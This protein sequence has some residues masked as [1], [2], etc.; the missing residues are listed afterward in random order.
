MGHPQTPLAAAA[1]WAEKMPDRTYLVQPIAGD[2]VVEYSWA[3][4]MDQARRMATWLKGQ[5][6]PE[7]SQI[8]IV[9]KNCAHWVIADLAIWAA[10]HV[11]VP[12]FATLSADGAQ[13]I[14]EHS[15][16]KLLFVGK[17][18]VWD[19]MKAGFPAD[20]PKVGLPLAPPDES[21]QRWDD[22]VRANEPLATL[23]ERTPDSVATIIYTSGSTGTPKGVMTSFRSLAETG[24]GIA[25][26]L[27][28]VPE[29]RGLSY[30]P[31]AHSFERWI[32]ETVSLMAAYQLYFA[33]SADTFVQDLRRARP[34]IFISVPRLWLK[35]QLGVFKKM[36]PKKLARLLKIPILGGIVRK[37]ILRGLGLDSVRF[38]G[39]GSAPIPAE[40]I[41]WYR[42]LGLELLEGYGMTENGSYS[43]VS[44]PGRVR[45]GYVGE[46]LPGVEHK[47]GE[48]D[49]V[50]VKGPGTM[51]G[52]FKA[53][54]LTA[55]V[56]EPD[57]WL[58]TGDQ[59]LIDEQNRLKITG[60]VKEL[61]KTSKGKYVSPSTIENALLTS[62]RLELACVSGGGFPQ[63]FALVV[64]SEETRK[65]L[66]NGGDRAAVEAELKAHLDAV[67]ALLPAY[68]HLQFAVV[69][70]EPWSTENGF[71]TPTMK[72]KRPVIES[73]YRPRLEGWYEQRRRVIW[74]E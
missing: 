28:V 49:E 18:D 38:A 68:E 58:H 62:P 30:L 32:G 9:S 65:E 50:L 36:P 73:A 34:T 59:G 21:L 39:S 33:E 19:E 61:F 52:Y 54:E 42:N 46:P 67:N 26:M 72:L 35:F 43:H 29:D 71:L 13:K 45:V 2:H 17:L 10:G 69:M 56:L 14:F 12:Y 55:E 25:E 22:I 27:G 48:N 1:R 3:E 74:E 5:G 47:I 70:K 53:P 63:P 4:V 20:V 40:L 44:K 66:Q 15:E 51:L 24:V 64:L 11:S 8:G 6:L 41:A 23:P 31:M 16:T 57:G 60:R 37:K 7:P